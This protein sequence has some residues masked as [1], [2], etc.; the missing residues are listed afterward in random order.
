MLVWLRIG[1][2]PARLLDFS[3]AESTIVTDRGG[4]VLYEARSDGGSRTVL[5]RADALPSTLVAATVAAEDHRFWSH[6]G[7]DPLA[8]ARA[9]GRNIRRRRFSE[10]GSTITQQVAKLLLARQAATSPRGVTTKVREAVLA[11][12]LEHRLSK[13]EILALYL[14]LAPYGNQLVGAESAS[15]EYFGHGAALLTPA[16]AAFLAALPQRPTRFNP[17]RDPERVRGRQQYVIERMAALGSLSAA[18]AHEALAERLALRDEPAV[19]LAPHF[20]QRVLSATVASSWP[21]AATVA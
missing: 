9:V 21:Q 13:R 19:F 3:G 5:L 15:R 12:R 11:L 8:L 2:L 7:I 4:E 16:Q 6:H 14:N 1:P 18:A 20:V 17:H 10:G